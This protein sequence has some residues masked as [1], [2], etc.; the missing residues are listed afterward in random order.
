MSKGVKDLRYNLKSSIAQRDT[1]DFYIYHIGFGCVIG[2]WI[3]LGLVA[4]WHLHWV[5]E[6]VRARYMGHGESS[7][8]HGM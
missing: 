5:M 1:L 7:L 3:D 4:H 2:I 8:I 6:L